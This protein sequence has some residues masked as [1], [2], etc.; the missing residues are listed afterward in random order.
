[1]KLQR[2]IPTLL[3]LLAGVMLLPG[4]LID[5]IGGAFTKAPNELETSAAASARKLIDQAFDGVDPARLV[6]FHTHIVAIGTT[7]TGAFVNPKMRRGLNL[8]R[9]KFLIY[10]SASGIKTVEN[11]DQEYIERLVHLAR[12][13]KRHGKYRILALDRHYN[14]DG[15]VNLSKTNMYVPNDYVVDLAKRYADIF[16][17]V[18]SVH[19]YRSDALAELDKWADA[20][21]KYVKWLPNAM[22]IDPA[23]QSVE[24]FYRRMK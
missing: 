15:T 19:P 21:V 5:Q 14:R 10:A 18:I 7:V 16:S 6:D 22:G 17:P 12:A 1:M 4:C 3:A 9:L 20:G 24:P 23:A 2:P 8:E 13:I 11:A